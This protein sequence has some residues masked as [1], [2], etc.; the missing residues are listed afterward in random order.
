MIYLDIF[1][2]VSASC[3]WLYVMLKIVG[4]IIDWFDGIKDLKSDIE[5]LKNTVKNYSYVIGD[6]K[7]RVEN[8]EKKKR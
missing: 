7:E 6:L 4:S 8:L 5:S 2:W 3:L 1:L